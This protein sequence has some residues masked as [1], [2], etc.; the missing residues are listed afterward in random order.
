ME[1]AVN[2][3]N[4]PVKLL[5]VTGSPLDGTSW[6]RAV[7]PLQQMALTYPIDVTVT[8][9]VDWS[10]ACGVDLAF[11]H[12]PD[13]EEAIGACRLLNAFGVPVWADYDDCIMSI[14]G[15]NPFYPA[16]RMPV[17]V[18]HLVKIAG[19]VQAIT[20]STEPVKEQYTSLHQMYLSYR[21]P[22]R[23]CSMTDSKCQNVR[24]TDCVFCGGA[25]THKS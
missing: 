15:R 6:Y 14:P 24:M 8:D 12:R 13:S 18:D 1:N 23:K 5:V 16:G 9:R 2:A 3:L 19:L 17:L 21:M 25:V 10:V 7:L 4:R 22:I 20:V 11:M